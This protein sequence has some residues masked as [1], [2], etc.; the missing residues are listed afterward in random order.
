VTSKRPSE[1][2]SQ[3]KADADL[4]RDIS[5]ASE[6]LERRLTEAVRAQDGVVI[7]R[8][9]IIGKYFTFVLSSNSPWVLSC[10]AAGVSIVFGASVSGQEGSAGNDVEI[11]L[12]DS[13]VDEKDCAVLG[14]RLGGS[15][16]R[17]DTR[18]LFSHLRYE[19]ARRAVK[20]EA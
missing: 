9:P 3:V 6:E 14:P 16:D 12:A 2:G 13:T 7:I 19:C 8:D 15:G 5:R 18:E 1:A 17:A 10:G 20:H 11:R 4:M